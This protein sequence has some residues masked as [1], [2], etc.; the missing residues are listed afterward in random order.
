MIY[1]LEERKVGKFFDEDLYEKTYIINLNTELDTDGYYYL[2]T[3]VKQLISA[4]IQISKSNFVYDAENSEEKYALNLAL[5]SGRTFYQLN[6]AFNDGVDTAPA[7]IV[8]A[9]YS[10]FNYAMAKVQYTK[11]NI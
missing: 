6:D 10:S 2:D 3:S 1:S 7:N 8:F 4:E 5:T 11:F 9:G